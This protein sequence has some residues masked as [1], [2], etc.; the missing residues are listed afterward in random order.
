MKYA[1]FLGEETIT[2]QEA[3]IRIEQ[4]S[5]N[6][7]YYAREES[8]IGVPTTRCI[9]E[10]LF[11]MAILKS[12]KAYLPIDFKYPKKRLTSII[13]NSGLSFCLTTQADEELARNE[14]LTTIGISG[15][16]P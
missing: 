13:N 9:E 11:V 3:Y 15:D 6:I 10:I 16:N 5:N 14:G 2:Y 4:I 1:L 12:G 8:F 7:Q